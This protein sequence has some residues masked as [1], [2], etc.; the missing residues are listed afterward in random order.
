[1]LCLEDSGLSLGLEGICNHPGPSGGAAQ[2][3]G[4]K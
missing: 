3:V 4:R 1:M 2:Q